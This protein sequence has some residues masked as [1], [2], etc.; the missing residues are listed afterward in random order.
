MLFV[1]QAQYSERADRLAGRLGALGPRLLFAWQAQH[2]ETLSLLSQS[3][4]LSRCSLR[5]RRST[6][7]G[8]ADSL[9]AAALCVV[10]AVLGDSVAAL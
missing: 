1:G 3:W 4:R 9:D 8:P 5:G 6:L 10:G 7:R 2:L